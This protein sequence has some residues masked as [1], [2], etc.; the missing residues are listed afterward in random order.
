M[1]TQNNDRYYICKKELA[2]GIEKVIGSLRIRATQPLLSTAHN[3]LSLF[4][5]LYAPYILLAACNSLSRT[6]NTVSLNTDF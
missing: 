6:N 2:T 1:I 4:A 3:T 5:R